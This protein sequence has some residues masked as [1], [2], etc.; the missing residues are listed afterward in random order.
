MISAAKR[1][2][3]V[4]EAYRARVRRVVRARRRGRDLAGFSHGCGRK[5]QLAIQ[6]VD[7]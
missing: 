2:F 5:R 7:G 3:M 1:Q 4:N 6:A